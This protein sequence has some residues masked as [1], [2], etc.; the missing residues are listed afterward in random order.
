M[1]AGAV[2]FTP[3]GV[4]VTIGQP[5]VVQI[6]ARLFRLRLLGLHFDTDKTF[7]L[8]SAMKGIRRLKRIYDQHP[9]AQVLVNGHAD[10]AADAP[11]NLRLSEERARSIAAFLQ[12]QVDFWMEFYSPGRQ[13]TKI[14]GTIEDQEMLSV[15]TDGAAPFYS[16]PIDGSAFRTRDAIARFQQADGLAADGVAGHDTR[17]ALVTKYMQQDGTTLP[18]G[19]HL[20]THG[21]GE[22]HPADRQPGEPPPADG[23]PD[24]RDRRVEI[25]FFDVKIDPPPEDQCPQGGCPEYPQWVGNTVQTIDL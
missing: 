18:A 16:G 11:H 15:L 21:C 23:V 13:G 14:W 22:F 19:A 7:L 8:P 25:F 17:T 4:S 20:E 3:G 1:P 2:L 12:D 5:A 10:R 6:P 9:G 24:A